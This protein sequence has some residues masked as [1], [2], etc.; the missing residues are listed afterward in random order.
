MTAP[1]A[2]QQL[3]RQ[4]ANTVT[5]LTVAVP[6]ALG[7]ALLGLTM[8]GALNE[9]TQLVDAGSLV[10]WGMPVARVLH[11]AMAAVTVGLLI[12]AAFAL[13]ARRTDHGA[14]SSVQHRAA[15]WA[16]TSGAVWFLAAVA[17]IVFTGANTIGAPIG[18]AVFNRIFPEFLFR[19]EA[20]QVYL[21][22]AIAALIATVLAA[23]A[24]RVTTLAVATVAALFALLPLSLSGH[25]AGSLEHANAVNSLAIHLVGVCVWVGGLVAV[26][27]LRTRTKGAT[28]RVIARY[29]ALAGWA[30]G[31]VAFSGVVNASLRLTGPL[32][33]VTTSYGWLI[34][35]KAGAL[36]LLGVA[37]AVQR[38]KIVPGLLREPTNRRLFVRFALA[39][40]VFM[41]IAIGASVAVSRSQP[42][43]PQAPTVGADTRDGLIGYTYPD[44]QTLQR[45]L[46]AWHWDWVWTALAVTGIVWYLLAVRKL[47]QRGDRWPIGRT[48]SWV[49][50]CAVFIWTMNGGPAVY[51]MIHFSSHMIQHMLL[52]M[53]VPLPLVLGGPVLLALRTLPIRNDG[54]RGAREWLL[55]FVHS[56]WMQ[57]LAQPAVAGVIFAGSLVAFYFTGAFQASMQSHEWHV[58]MVLHFVLSG[59]LFF[60]V[61]VGIDPGP[62]RPPYPILIIALL[63][64]L[65]FHAFFGVAVMSSATVYALDWF[66]ALGQT[67][68][69][70][71]LADQRTGGGIAW[72]AGELPMVF[73]ALLVVRNWRRSEE[74][75]AKRLDRQADR[76]GDADLTAYN[77]RLA[78]LDDRD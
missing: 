18:S 33:L 17:G 51:G 26:L 52:M 47:R 6:V 10:R 7:C 40:I 19:L 30:F 36:V 3:S 8:T 59:Y 21:V 22:S 45:F 37:G 72:G 31:A 46:T 61:F 29:S 42:P 12:V 1:T 34:T 2:P 63:A 49:L 38:R 64:T 71:L 58:A 67:D 60:W 23:F 76:D 35:V 32:D 62:R 74:R 9:E 48:I 14:V 13:P 50:G 11:D 65:A 16:A 39:E 28:G 44:P 24:T 75:T 54:S 15:R 55:L 66:R 73:V 25:A 43:I 56:K 20:G 4:G 53:F 78:A 57:F 70:A 77:D 69:A 41:A 27:L 68:T 5:V